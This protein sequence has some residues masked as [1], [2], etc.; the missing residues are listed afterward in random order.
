MAVD[1]YINTSGLPNLQ[2]APTGTQNIDA[3][4]RDGNRYSIKSLT[5]STTGVFYGLLWPV[6]VFQQLLDQPTHALG[7]KQSTVL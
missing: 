7:I 6:C 4:S 3:I 5:G 2:D 1:Y